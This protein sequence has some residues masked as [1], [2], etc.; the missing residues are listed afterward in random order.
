MVRPRPGASA[1]LHR[2]ARPT[3]HLRSTQLHRFDEAVA[4][5]RSPEG[6]RSGQRRGRLEFGAAST[7]DRQFRGRLGRARG[8]RGNCPRRPTRNF[9]QPMWLGEGAVEGKT[10]LVYAD[11]GMGDSIQ[12][13]RYVPM[14]AARGARVILVVVE[15]AAFRCCRNCPASRSALPSSARAT[16]PA[17]DMHCPMSQPA[18]GLRNP[19]RHAFRPQTAYLPAPAASACRPGKSGSALTT[20]CGSAWSGPAIPRT[21][22]DHNRSIPLR[23]L[24]RILDVDATFVSLQ[25]DPRPDDQAMLRERTDIVDLTADLTDFSETAALIELPRSR[26]HRSTPASP[27]SPPRSA[28]RPGSCCPTRRTTAGCSIAT[29]APGI[30]PCGCSGRAKAATTRACSIGC[31]ANC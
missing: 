10:I 24:S 4:I 25:K 11:E 6:D 27:I 31:E 15:R 29:T 5:Y 3:R 14:L 8:A 12:F 30:R 17:F 7:A 2:G 19:A 28:A 1:G 18:A 16:L 23:M 20:D 13:A 22:N 26:D 21:S 9:R